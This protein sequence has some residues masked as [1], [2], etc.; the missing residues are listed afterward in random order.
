MKRYL[1]A[2]IAL[3]I[4][5]GGAVTY[6]QAKIPG[7]PMQLEYGR[8]LMTPEEM[9]QHRTAM[10]SAKTAEERERIRLEQHTAMRQRA[11]ERGITLP[12]MPPQRDMRR[13]PS[14]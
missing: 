2:G 12:E 7:P 6:A 4:L 14:R 9:A 8:P 1:T 10:R 11:A 13:G 5:T 3:T